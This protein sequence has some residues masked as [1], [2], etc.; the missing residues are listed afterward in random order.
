MIRSRGLRGLITAA[1]CCGMFM[2]QSGLMA[3]APKPTKNPEVRPV[4]IRKVTDVALATGGVLKGRFVDRQGKGIASAPVMV[5]HNGKEVASAT[6]DTEGRFTVKNLRGGEHQVV[7]AQYVQPCRLWSEKTAPPAAKTESLIVASQGVVRG[8]DGMVC[9]MGPDFLTL[10]L[11]GVGIAGAV[12][13]GIA[14]AKLNDV[15]DKLDAL[16]TP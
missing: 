11:L 5:V 4:Q 15:E 8:Q 16:A 1:V 6:T 10:G 2:S 14:V 3:A 7:M 12:L 9:G 13:G